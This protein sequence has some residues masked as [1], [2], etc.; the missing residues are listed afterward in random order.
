MTSNDRAMSPAETAAYIE[1]V[2]SSLQTL[3]DRSQLGFL[4]Y[5][6]A[7]VREE[8]ASEAMRTARREPAA[9]VR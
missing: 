7:M 6:I 5:L 9:A 1:Q 3:A 2:A 8:A 4:S